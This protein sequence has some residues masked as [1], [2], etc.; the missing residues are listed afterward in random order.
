MQREGSEIGR[1]IVSALIQYGIEVFSVT[2][3][4][5]FANRFYEEH[6]PDVAFLRA[7]RLEDGK[8]TFRI[9]PGE[10]LKTSFGE[11]LYQEIFGSEK[12]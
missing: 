2:H 3:L 4:F 5:E 8:R 6:L 10:P 12:G 9:I 1:Q 7:E 11:D